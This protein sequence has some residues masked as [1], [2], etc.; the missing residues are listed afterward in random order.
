M[1]LRFTMFMAFSLIMAL[2]VALLFCYLYLRSR[3]KKEHIKNQK[4]INDLELCNAKLRVLVNITHEI[5]THITLISTPLTTL[6][7]EE[8]DPQRKLTFEMIKRN[9]DHIINLIN[10]ISDLRKIDQ[11]AMQMHMAETN[12]VSFINH[13][14]SLFTHQAHSRQIAMTFQHDMNELP[15]W[16]DPQNFDKVIIN[17]LSN[18]FKFTPTGGTIT[19]HLT[20]CSDIA[21]ITI[22]NNGPK[23]PNDEL[24]H[25]FKRFFYTSANN[26]L[27]NSGTGI[28]LHLA[29]SLVELHHGT[30]TARNLK[31]GCEFA[32][33]I[34]LGN[35]HLSPTEMSVNE[36][37]TSSS[38]PSSPL[39][40]SPSS[41]PLHHSTPS[42][43]IIIAEDNDDILNYLTSQ[44]QPFY[45]IIPTVNGHEALTATLRHKP[46]LVLSDII[47]PIMDGLTLC[48]KI[49]T[50]PETSHIPV[51]LLSAK[52]TDEDKLLG[53]ECQADAYFVK[54]FNIDHLQRTIANII[55]SRYQLRLK[56]QR[57]DNLEQQVN[58]INISSPDERLLQ[59]VM[60]VINQHI[61]NS[62]L[63]IDMIATQVGL[64]RVHLHRKMKELTGQTP[65]DF[66]R[67]I[68][69]KKAAT[70]LTKKGMNIGEVTYSCGFLNT[71]SFSTIFKKYYGISPREYNKKHQE[72][73]KPEESE[74]H[75]A[76]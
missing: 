57:N 61:S 40:A 62:E 27:Q 76:H 1:T 4:N 42:T 36:K 72:K 30:I 38:L 59:R 21:H 53:L 3:S 19:I 60:T 33:D 39:P 12:L 11:G 46:S 29:Q 17:I 31:Q 41:L 48:S 43:T 24:G 56:Y 65:H 23:I 74:S 73:T 28:G 45:H 75:G 34:P 44:L 63:S 54:P 14:L 58:S 15:I 20:T 22:S 50:N 10:Q 18:A 52:N 55:E 32:I 13:I 8:T 47:M 7:Q 16:I 35:A 70:L 67:S 64:S 71:A 25:I 5:R 6:I 9:A 69:L 26:N 51:I 2:I 37:G 66:I 68:R 49:K